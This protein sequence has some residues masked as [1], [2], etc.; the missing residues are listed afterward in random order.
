MFNQDHV[1]NTSSVRSSKIIGLGEQ[2]EK[3]IKVFRN[4]HVRRR[5]ETIYADQRSYI[6]VLDASRGKGRPYALIYPS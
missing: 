6:P 5:K 4:L 1:S 3:R 2:H